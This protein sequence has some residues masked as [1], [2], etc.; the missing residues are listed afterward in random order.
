MRRRNRELVKWGSRKCGHSRFRSVVGYFMSILISSFDYFLFC[1]AF[2]S[3][4]LT[5]DS[6]KSL[7]SPLCYVLLYFYEAAESGNK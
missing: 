4:F 7:S 2:G 6:W 5:L 3:L 1:F